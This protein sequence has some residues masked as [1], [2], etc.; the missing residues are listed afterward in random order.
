MERPERTLVSE[1]LERIARPHRMWGH[2]LNLFINIGSMNHIKIY[3][4]LFLLCV[5]AH[6]STVAQT[7]PRPAIML[8][9][10]NLV[11]QVSGDMAKRYSGHFGIGGGLSYQP[12]KNHFQFGAKFSYFYGRTVKEDVMAPFRTATD[13]L[14]IGEDRFLA[15]MRLRERGFNAQLY[16][17]GIFPFPERATFR[18]GIK[19]QLGVGFLQH[20]IRMQDEAKALR[21]FTTDV[22]KG[23][24]RMCNGYSIVPFLGY[25]Y[26]S[27]NGRIN[28]YFGLEP[29]IGFTGSRRTWNYDTNT[30]DF[31]VKR[32][33]MLW[34]V[35]V[36]WYLPFF[37]ER[38]DQVD[39]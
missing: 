1:D 14:L 20:K 32:L 39:Y 30:T 25:E 12:I 9:I 6:Q 18:H 5:F 31:G 24:D 27:Y 35:K 3:F 19:W 16:T 13:G 23:L 26:L 34:N 7:A 2:S 11:G 28:F 36:G 37:I 22:L 4:S 38:A 8:D 10:H 21:Q 17:G 15:E 33:D 29:V